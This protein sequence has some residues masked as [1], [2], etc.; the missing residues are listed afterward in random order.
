MAADRHRFHEI[1]QLLLLV[2]RNPLEAPSVSMISYSEPRFLSIY[3]TPAEGRPVK[4]SNSPTTTHTAP[5]V[6]KPYSFPTPIR[7]IDPLLSSSPP[8]RTTRTKFS[9][10]DLERLVR[11]AAEEDPWEKRHG[12]IGEAWGRVLKRLQSEN[13]FENST[14]STLQ[15]KV[16]NFIAW[17]KVCPSLS[18]VHAR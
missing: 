14:I 2:V 9:E 8:S 3:G 4:M 11:F 16:N 7:A 5:A 1:H 15:N 10:E 12:Q 6:I 13:R 17:Q 18:C